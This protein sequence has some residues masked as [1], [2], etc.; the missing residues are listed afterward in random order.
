MFVNQH[1]ANFTRKKLENSEDLECETFRVL[2]L[3][4][5]NVKRVYQI[6]ISVPV[7][8]FVHEGPEIPEEYSEPSQTSKVDIF[9][10]IVDSKQP[11]IIFAKSSILDVQLG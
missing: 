6:C 7:K 3:H 5:T 2:S 11:A 10:K 4:N 1:F 8:L 9:T